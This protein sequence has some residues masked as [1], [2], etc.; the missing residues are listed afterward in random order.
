LNSV[1]LAVLYGVAGNNYTP[2]INCSYRMLVWCFVLAT[3]HAFFL[4]FNLGYLALAFLGW[5]LLRFWKP[6]L[7]A[8][9]VLLFF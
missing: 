6:I 4:L 3:F 8:I 5:A 7:E 1:F 9:F 2:A